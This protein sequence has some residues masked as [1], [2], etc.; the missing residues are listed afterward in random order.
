[1]NA[2]KTPQLE[3]PTLNYGQDSYEYDP[4]RHVIKKNGRLLKIKDTG[5][6]P[7]DLKYSTDDI[8]LQRFATRCNEYS[9]ATRELVNGSLQK[10][11]RAD[12]RRTRRQLSVEAAPIA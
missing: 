9:N 4:R 11:T 7:T 6:S 8:I 3:V 12:Q 10:K 5:H 2:S 1:M